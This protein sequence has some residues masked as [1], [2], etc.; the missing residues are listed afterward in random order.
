MVRAPELTFAKKPEGSL[1]TSS[2]NLTSISQLKESK[3]SI[4]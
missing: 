1:V 3:A 2:Q 4:I